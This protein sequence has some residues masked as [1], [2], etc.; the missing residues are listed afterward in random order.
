[1]EEMSRESKREE[2]GEREFGEQRED[3]VGGRRGEI[4]KKKMGASGCGG[5]GKA[6][7]ERGQKE[8]RESEKTGMDKRDKGGSEN[9]LNR[10]KN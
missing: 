6:E 9:S 3:L 8:G 1:M 10:L 2:E 4:K 5:M 7:I